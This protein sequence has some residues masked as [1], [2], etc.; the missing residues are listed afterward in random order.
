MSTGYVYP[1]TYRQDQR[2]G[3]I[4]AMTTALLIL[5][6]AATVLL[7][8]AVVRAVR[9]DPARAIPCSHCDT[10]SPRWAGGSTSRWSV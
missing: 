9:Q 4:S 10:F 2:A 6:L 5:L 1:A 3:R 7:V 8:V